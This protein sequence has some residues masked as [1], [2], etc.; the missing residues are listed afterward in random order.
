[1]IHIVV[2]HNNDSVKI[3]VMTPYV[4]DGGYKFQ[5]MNQLYF[6]YHKLY[7]RWMKTYLNMDYAI[8]RLDNDISDITKLFGE[9]KVTKYKLMEQL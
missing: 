3:E 9:S 6:R 4:D 2:Y 5:Q 1:M 7:R 8:D